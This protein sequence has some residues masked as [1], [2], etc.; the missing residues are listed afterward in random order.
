VE[1]Y[2][3]QYPTLNADADALL[4]FIYAEFVLRQELGEEPSAEEYVRRFPHQATQLQR[5]FLVDRAL[6]VEANSAAGA[7]SWNTL[8]PPAPPA[9]ALPAFIG[10]YRVVS[11]LDAGGQALVYRAV[12]PTLGKDV[13][14]KLSRILS[15]DPQ[16]DRD[17]LRAEGRIL[18]ELDHPHLA[19][20]YDLDW[21]EG[22]VFLV[23]EYLRG[24]TLEQYAQQEKPAPSQAAL[25]TAQVARALALAHQ[26]GILHRDVK[27]KNILIDE[28][29]Q[30]RLLDFGLAQVQNAWTE[31]S[32]EPGR[33]SGTLQFMAPEQARGETAH[34]DRR[35]D[36]FALGGVL[37]YLLTG[38]PLF[39]GNTLLELLQR[40]R[41][42]DFDRTALQAPHVPRRLAAVCLRALAA[43]P[44]DRYAR[45]EDLAAD[46]EAF[47]RQ[48]RRLARLAL[49]AVPVLLAAVALIWWFNSEPT[50][51]SETRSPN[52]KPSVTPGTADDTRPTLFVRVWD[53]DRYRDLIHLVPL[54]TGNQLQVQA[55]AP[56]ELHVSLFLFTS[57][58]QLKLLVQR[59][60]GDAPGPLRF[61]AQQDKSVSLIGP[62][63][64]EFLLVCG[65]RAGPIGVADLQSLWGASGRWAALPRESVLRLQHSQ[66][67]VEQKDRDFGKIADRS[68]PEGE[69]ERRLEALRLRLREPFD[70][71]EGLAFAHR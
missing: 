18:A 66:V 71:F 43:N 60:P 57:D 26:R 42:C 13:V 20:V 23:M 11:A 55:K 38:K 27:P 53:R 41:A 17:G 49:A 36:L 40:A 56:A 15:D 34:L 37:Y 33:I 63:G 14:I 2:L 59:S 1:A 65:R 19:R 30:P 10:K 32:D 29:G 50:A 12:H 46:L 64:T 4:D 9:P 39:A 35:S 62:G 22:R 31:I 45:A 25:L 48:P 54:R 6:L 24:R 21:H 5:L 69:I 61:P 44:A 68:D 70:Y 58:G 47:G 51:S 28:T 16:A 8:A 67:F 7:Y 52:Q 3:Q